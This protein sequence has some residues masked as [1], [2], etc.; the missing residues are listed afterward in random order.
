MVRSIYSRSGIKRS[1]AVIVAD[2]G[3]SQFKRCMI[4]EILQGWDHSMTTLP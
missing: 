4:E 1:D 2:Q 3:D